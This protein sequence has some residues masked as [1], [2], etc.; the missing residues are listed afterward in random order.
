MTFHDSN[1][2]VRLKPVFGT[3]PGVARESTGEDDAGARSP[4]GGVG[5]DH[6]FESTGV[7]RGWW[8]LTVHRTRP[9]IVG[10]PRRDRHARFLQHVRHPCTSHPI[11]DPYLSA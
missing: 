11:R 2:P 5:Y 7:A 3:D 8:G 1:L 10:R 4:G 6:F 9:R